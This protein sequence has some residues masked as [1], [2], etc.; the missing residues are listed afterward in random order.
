MAGDDLHTLGSEELTQVHN[1]PLVLRSETGVEVAETLQETE[2]HFGS[3]A[4]ISVFNNTLS[5]LYD[6]LTAH[7]CYSSPR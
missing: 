2:D 5:L 6:S 4:G 1:A 3:D 7:L